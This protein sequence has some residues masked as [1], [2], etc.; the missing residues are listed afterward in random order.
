MY[1]AQREY[2]RIYREGIED[3]ISMMHK[4]HVHRVLATDAACEGDA[5][6]THQHTKVADA[7]QQWAAAALSLASAVHSKVTQ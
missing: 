5:K 7:A 2:Q 3:C 1:Q 4:A 6:R